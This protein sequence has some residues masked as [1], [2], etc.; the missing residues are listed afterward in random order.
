[1]STFSSLG[2]TI[3]SIFIRPAFLFYAIIISVFSL[4]V[5]ACSDQNESEA[6]QFFLKGNLQLE[7]KEYAGAI[8]YYD[9][10]LAK[11]SDFADVH[12]NRGIAYLRLGELDKALEDFNKAIDIDRT[13]DQAYFNRAG[14]LIDKHEFSLAATDLEQIR[15]SYQDST[16]YYLKWGDLKSQQGYYEQA[17][18]EY[19]RSLT[20]RPENVQALVNRGVIYFTKK[21]FKEAQKDFEQALKLN[22]Q[23]ELAYNNLALIFARNKQ[24]EKA[25]QFIDRAL[26]FDA[27]NP[28]YLNNK[29]Y[30][31]LLQNQFE[32]AKKLIDQS[33]TKAPENSYAHRN[34]GIYFLHKGQKTEALS[35]FQKSYSID[36]STDQIHAWLG[37][38]L[39]LNNQKEKACKMWRQGQSLGDEESSV[40]FTQ[41]CK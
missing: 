20:L 18:S 33:L 4:T 38:A 41:K 2:T 21:N 1:M 39:F 31:L 25:L 17:L 12:S 24:P 32:E 5:T 27:V 30:V 14:A 26:D 34:L 8:H 28:I 9:E 3:S 29:G 11:K 15:K 6:A 10:A 19:D 16:N 23:Q 22:P 36:P 35:A 40:K 7:Q 13:F 37:E